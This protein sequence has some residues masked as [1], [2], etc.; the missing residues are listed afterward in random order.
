MPLTPEQEA[1]L[2][3][4]REKAAAPAPPPVP[5]PPASLG[6]G[7]SEEKKR[8]L[9]E[10]QA[11]QKPAVSEPVEVAKTAAKER[12]PVA[13]TA[14]EQFKFEDVAGKGVQAEDAIRRGVAYEV[15]KELPGM[16]PEVRRSEV[17]RRMAEFQAE[18]LPPL[19]MGVF[20][21][22]VTFGGVA[23]SPAPPR[24]VPPAE[25]AGIGT[26]L[27][28]Q[29]RVSEAD[30]AR[31]K[32]ERAVGHFDD[33][34][35]E[36]KIA[37]LPEEEQQPQ[38]DFYEAY[39]AAFGKVQELNP[40]E[41]PEAIQKDLARQI[42]ALQSGTF[43]KF[44]DDPANRMGYTGDPLARALQRQV[45]TGVVPILEPGQLELVNTLDR[46]G[47]AR[48]LGKTGADVEQ[49]LRTKGVEITERKR[50]PTGEVGGGGR[51]LT[52]EV[53]V[54]T[55][56]FRPATEAEIAAAKSKAVGLAETREGP[57]PFYLTPE[58]D[59]VLANIEGSAKGGTFFAK[60]YPTG[61]TVESPVSFGVRVIMSPLNAG[62]GLVS[63]AFTPAEITAEER[64][65]RPAL[66]RDSSAATYNVAEGRG[67][68]GEIEDLYKYNPD[69]T[70]R[71]YAWVGTAAGFAAD[72]LSFDIATVR[73]AATGV[74]EGLA[75][76]RAKRVAGAAGTAESALARGF[77]AGSKEFLDEIGLV[78]AA[79][80]IPLGDVRLGV[81]AIVGDSYRAGDAYLL[82]SEEAQAAGKTADQAHA[83]GLAAAEAAAPRSKAIDDIRK[84]GPAIEADLKSGK[85]FDNA[86]EFA[87]YRRV[88]E[89]ADEAQGLKL[90]GPL[91]FAGPS[92]AAGRVGQ[93]LRPYLA[94]AVRSTPELRPGLDTLVSQ[95][96]PTQTKLRLI[97][98][99]SEVAKLP[100]EAQARFYDTIRQSAA[101]QTGFKTIDRA[102]AG[103]DPGR[104]VVR[105]TPNTFAPSDAVDNI[106]AKA[107]A[108]E[109]G[110]LVQEI[111]RMGRESDGTYYVGTLDDALAQATVRLATAG[112]LDTPS[113]ERI[114][115]TLAEGRAKG[116]ESVRGEDLRAVMYAA[117]DAVAE[118]LRLG[119]REGFLAPGG[120][121]TV[122]LRGEVPRPSPRAIT[123]GA[124]VGFVNSAL[125]RV[126]S[127]VTEAF[128]RTDKISRLLTSGQ[129]LA[130]E[131]AKRAI[132]ALP[133]LLESELAAAVGATLTE[134]VSNLL[135][136][137]ITGV[138]SATAF[139]QNVAR[140]SVFSRTQGGVLD[141]LLG[142]FSFRDPYQ[143][144]NGKGRKSLYE[145]S[146]RYGAKLNASRDAATLA[147]MLPDYIDEVRAIVTANLKKDVAR[148]MEGVVDLKTRPQDVVLGAYFRGE[149]DR[150]Y[151]EALDK[152]VDFE[153]E[154][155]GAY[156]SAVRTALKNVQD[157]NGRSLAGRPLAIAVA[158]QM[159]HGTTFAT[160]EDLLRLPQI[161]KW[162]KAFDASGVG[163][164]TGEQLIRKF[165]AALLA[166][167]P[168]TV[169]ALSVKYSS[170]PA[171][172][173]ATDLE[174]LLQ[175]KAGLSE[176]SSPLGT[177]LGR[178]LKE[179]LGKELRFDEF[180]TE[181]GILAEGAS[182]G[183]LT[184]LGARKAVSNL[185]GAAN[186]AFYNLV[187]YLNPRFHGGNFITGPAISYATTGTLGRLQNPLSKILG[188]VR[189]PFGIEYDMADIVARAE[190]T[191]VFK[192][193]SSAN[194]D[195]RWLDLAN[196]MARKAGLLGKTERKVSN[197]AAF[198]TALADASDK[199]YRVEAMKAALQQGKTL[200]E[201]F[202]IG[203]KSLFD[204]G[205][206]TDVERTYVA[207]WMLF[208]NFF[209]N[210]LA[211]TFDSMLRDPARF[212]RQV[213]LTEDATRIAAED[214]EQWSQMRFYTPY[215]A[216]VARIALSYAPQA[217]REGK[218]VMLP[219]MPYYDAVYL[220]TGL[221]STPGYV[222]SGGTN[223]VTGESEPGSSYVYDKLA[224]SV[225]LAIATVAGLGFAADV[226]ISKG[227]IPAAHA[228]MFEATGMLPV[229]AG[230]V[231][232][233]VRPARPDETNQSYNGNVYTLSDDDFTKY[234]K[235]VS[236]S[237]YLGASR[238]FKDY[239]DL[240]AMWG[241]FDGK[242][243]DFTVGEKVLQTTGLG[244]VSPVGTAASAETRAAD[245]QTQITQKKAREQAERSGLVQ[246][247][248]E[249]R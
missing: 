201:A 205:S 8:R 54:G 87:E 96:G 12:R 129:K 116:V 238:P 5:P 122:P 208:Y 14:R 2:R 220:I 75:L 179:V 49:A 194:L 101:L 171:E 71:Q 30:A 43:K 216:G 158:E 105:V 28:P 213:R 80:A 230:L 17:A 81:G 174:R 200:D 82:K 184:M 178:A 182:K 247:K 127:S 226:K 19:Y 117:T 232:L 7:L 193:Q 64:K 244:T 186:S 22:P 246:P 63:E 133:Q 29:T 131:D 24:N 214:D 128:P 72:L 46:I 10:L 13:T 21:P 239:G 109:E 50:Q 37:A 103:V 34:A 175:G 229:V 106:L 53:E 85:Y 36:V 52:E 83:D 111:L 27:R 31:I 176:V 138:G 132:G 92:K 190:T 25:P 136:G 231:D 195:P 9:A 148:S 41:S 58:R 152:I 170:V 156:N 150:V 192:S 183:N 104:F 67:F 4:L 187:L 89:A 114:L 16:S 199:L 77:K 74:R 235:L 185:I 204:Y 35:M 197:L 66:Y 237:Q 137:K 32:R 56:K 69:P 126:V 90:G 228:A 20:G 79:K 62:V 181:L 107:R 225:Q 218:V 51:P 26:A 86:D 196:T 113:A 68:M 110:Q 141:F 115:R 97:D 98:V 145:V 55:G 65:A 233:K 172:A 47:R 202:E 161:Q 221:L 6:E 168:P 143:M 57:V 1:R 124:N 241:A 234:K 219:N 164:M 151:S 125:Q 215:D 76:S 134:K 243:K 60:E 173:I 78:S 102:T 146:Q 108:S 177:E 188:P 93:I 11:K 142:N 3:E 242:F 180:N 140:S 165:G 149:A 189:D 144:V 222:I 123:F 224:P 248:L 95:R 153:P 236:F 240:V 249:E 166:D 191:G 162:M 207:R 121:K 169:G 42:K 135:L 163:T 94:A 223:P 91:L 167:V 227:Y 119:F 157:P 18:K 217:N 99:F 206:A 61:A 130:V 39:K 210:G 40:D 15:A 38:R 147:A 48:N 45:T 203:R 120:K 59:K 154:T 70:M 112:M 245:I 23:P 155:V 139:W 73:G 100:V 198:P 211:T 84:A 212:T 88:S 44:T 209:R 33:L 118:E 160:P 159:L